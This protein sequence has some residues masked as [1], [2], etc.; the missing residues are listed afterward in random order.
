MIK[1]YKADDG[2]K[3]WARALQFAYREEVLHDYNEYRAPQVLLNVENAKRGLIFYDGYRDLILSKVGSIATQLTA[4]MLRS[5]HIPY[6]LFTPLET[7]PEIS[8]EIFG[9]MIGIPI[10]KI[11]EIK[12]EYAGNGDKLLY[13]NDRT[14]FD[15]FVRYEALDGRIGGIGIEV[16]YTENEYPLGDKE[17]K[18]IAGD[19][20]RYRIMTVESGYYH[21]DLNIRMFLTAHH[22]RQIWRNHIL[23]YSMKHKGDVEIIHH[24]HLYP[25]QNEHFHLYALPDYRKLLTEEGN[26]S[27]K[28]ITYENY[29]ALLDKYRENEK[30]SAWVN[31]LRR[32]YLGIT[33]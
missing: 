22:L 2:F 16:K 11:L 14:S 32:R 19:N 8:A 7:M 15:A 24:V 1:E 18:D 4:N 12:I 10:N 29:F 33:E 5:E 6:N 9:E 28:T 25:Q 13:L 20:E 31:Y 17:G 30:V 26:E 27:F 23:G 3:R 21:P